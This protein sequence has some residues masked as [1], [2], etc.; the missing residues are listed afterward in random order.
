MYKFSNGLTRFVR[1]LYVFSYNFFIIIQCK[2]NSFLQ[3]TAKKR[4][5]QYVKELFF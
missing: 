1:T 3:I 5:S 2:C 4:A